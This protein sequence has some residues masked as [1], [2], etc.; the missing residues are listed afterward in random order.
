MLWEVEKC[1]QFPSQTEL[2]NN[3]LVNK[4]LEGYKFFSLSFSVKPVVASFV[5][6][7]AETFGTLGR[8]ATANEGD[9]VLGMPDT[10]L[11]E[12]GTVRLLIRL[13][14]YE[15][16]WPATLG[17]TIPTATTSADGPTYLSLQ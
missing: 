1:D 2:R 17:Q 13:S 15:R 11:G 12:S 5:P 3:A 4:T 10:E 9:S 16:Q 6:R 7:A 14:T 8:E